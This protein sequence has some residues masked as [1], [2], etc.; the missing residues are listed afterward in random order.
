MNDTKKVIFFE[1]VIMSKI[2]D[3]AAT[4]TDFIKLTKGLKNSF[5]AENLY[6]TAAEKAAIDTENTRASTILISE[7]KMSS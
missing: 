2:T 6:E 3:I 7:P 5:T 1:P 4:G